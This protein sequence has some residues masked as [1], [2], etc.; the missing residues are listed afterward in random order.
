[1]PSP[2]R[3]KKHLGQ[4]FLHNEVISSEIV[5]FITRRPGLNLLEVGPGGGALTQ[6]LL[7][8]KDVDFKAIEVDEEKAV[9]LSK[10]Y[11]NL[12]LIQGF[13]QIGTINQ[14]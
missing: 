1:M 11:P 3:L 9:Y 4:H 8:W 7:K 5:S 10:T 12:N 6:Y 2:Y 13:G 14:T